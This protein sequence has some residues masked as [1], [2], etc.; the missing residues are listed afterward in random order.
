MQNRV[1]FSNNWVHQTISDPVTKKLVSFLT[2]KDG[3]K[4]GYGTA[5]SISA[6]RAGMQL[7]RIFRQDCKKME[8][9]VRILHAYDYSYEQKRFKST[10][11]QNSKDGG[12]IS[13]FDPDCALGRSDS[14]CRHITKFYSAIS[15][16]PPVFWRRSI[17][18][19]PDGSELRAIPSD[20]GDDCHFDIHGLSNNKSG[21]FF[22]RNQVD[23]IYICEDG[24][25]VPLTEDGMNRHFPKN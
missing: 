9:F 15:D 23:S 2:K 24:I 17:Q 12:G 16:D 13:I 6:V 20:T 25:P 8:E 3:W 5:A 22:K 19:I 1:F 14:I 7:L 18:E 10:A 4:N 11:F 21:K